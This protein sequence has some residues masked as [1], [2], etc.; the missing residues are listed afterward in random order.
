M[1]IITRTHVADNL[2]VYNSALGLSLAPP[3]P[4]IIAAGY[5]VDTMNAILAAA[6]A[7]NRPVTIPDINQFARGLLIRDWAAGT[8]GNP[9]D[10]PPPA[11]TGIIQTATSMNWTVPAGITKVMFSWIV[12]GGGAGGS[13]HETVN[14]GA[15]GGGGSGGWHRWIEVNCNPGDNFGLNVGAGGQ[16]LSMGLAH[17]TQGQYAGQGG[18]S[19]VTLNGGEV[20]RA[21]GGGGGQNGLWN[22]VSG[23]GGS[24]GHAGAPNGS[25]GGSAGRAS[26]DKASDVGAPGAAGPMAGSFAG[27]AGN[28]GGGDQFS[29]ASAGKPGGGYGS[30]GGGAGYRDRKA[31]YIWAGGPGNSGFIEMIYPSQGATGGSA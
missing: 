24:G 13:S 27:A 3:P 30:S 28:T 31:P 18:D 10:P 14:G 6:A 15:G 29:G 16:P 1:G 23:N 4:G 17:D 2:A 12:A 5:Y 11:E 21:T 19:F 8:I 25:P 20:I 7:Q 9:P 22:N 26:G